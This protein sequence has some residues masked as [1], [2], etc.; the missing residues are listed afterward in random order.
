MFKENFSIKCRLY[1]NKKELYVWS[2]SNCFLQKFLK[3]I[4]GLIDMIFFQL[5]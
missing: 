1:V 5:S 3:K 2:F 4:K